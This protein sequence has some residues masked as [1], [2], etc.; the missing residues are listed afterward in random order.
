MLTPTD[1]TH[2]EMFVI[3]ARIQKVLSEEVQLS[4]FIRGE[5]IQIALK[6]DH[7]RPAS[8]T[9]FNLAFLWRAND[10]PTLSVGLVAWKLCN[11]SEDPDQYC[12]ETLCFC[13]FPGGGGGLAPCP[14]LDLRI[15]CELFV[16]LDKFICCYFQSRRHLV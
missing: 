16:F 4:F 2:C 9:T 7:H 10:C 12:L 6:A 13:D 1:I 8:G 14:P 15:H 11:I 5:R 3:H